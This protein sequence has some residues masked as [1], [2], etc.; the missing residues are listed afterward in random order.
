VLDILLVF[1]DPRVKDEG[2]SLL[3]FGPEVE[4]G[5][6]E[7]VLELARTRALGALEHDS[8]VERA[9]IFES[10]LETNGV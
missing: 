9:V 10:D 7:S 1:G 8:R 4:I 3:V 5:A 6:V 2:H